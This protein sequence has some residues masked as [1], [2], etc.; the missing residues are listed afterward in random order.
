VSSLLERA[1]FD[2]MRFVVCRPPQSIRRTYRTTCTLLEERENESNLE[3]SMKKALG[4]LMTMG[5]LASS[6]GGCS[7]G[8]IAVAGDK[9]VVLRQDWFLFGALRKAYVC[10]VLETGLSNCTANETP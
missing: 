7:Y 1:A 9:V 8:P 3:D 6:L 4:M 10:R 5:M 2:L